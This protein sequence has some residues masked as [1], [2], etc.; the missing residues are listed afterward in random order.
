[1]TIAPAA[2]VTPNGVGYGVLLNAAKTNGQPASIGT[3]TKELV[4][5]L[6]RGNGAR[7]VGDAQL[8]DV[9]GVQGRSVMLQSISPFPSADGQQQL[10]SDWLVT[11]PQS[12]DM[13]LFFIFVA[14]KSDFARFRPTYEAMLKSVQF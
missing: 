5:E 4:Q 10:E 3:I 9:N 14:P 13:I 8:I 11:V 7:A 2:G 12:D 6:Q 1:V